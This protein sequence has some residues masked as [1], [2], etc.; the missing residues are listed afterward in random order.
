M[1]SAIG[2][3]RENRQTRAFL[4]DVMWDVVAVGNTMVQSSRR[5]MP[6]GA[7]R[8]RMTWRPT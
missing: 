7:S 2:P 1:R 5:I 8:S 6:S 3:I 4:L